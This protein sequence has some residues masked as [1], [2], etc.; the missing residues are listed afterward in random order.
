LQLLNSVWVGAVRTIVDIVPKEIIIGFHVQWTW[1]SGPP[2]PKI[3][4][5]GNSYQTHHA[6]HPR[7]HLLYVCVHHS[8]GKMCPHAVLHERS[9]WPHFAVSVGTT[10]LLWCLPWRSV[11]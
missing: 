3:D 10:D 7:W 8:A 1:W 5:M 9:E 4:V 11:Q 6:G 2:T